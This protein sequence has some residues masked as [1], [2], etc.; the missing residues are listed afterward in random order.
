MA[1]VK[2]K[3]VLLTGA[4]G[5]MGGEAFKELLQRRDKCDIVLILRPSKPNREAFGKYDGQPGVTIVWGDLCNPND[6][7]K[8]VTGV[9]HVLHPAALIA[10]EAD[11][12]PRQCRQVNF[13]GTQNIIA[14]IKKQPNN[15]DGIR[16][17]YIGSVA[18]YGDRLP[19]IHWIRVGDPLKPSVGDY[20]A[21]TKIAAE[22]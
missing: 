6:V 10:P 2:K 15:G 5:S 3:R 18:E 11:S 21:T 8:A 13:G 19:P 14:A 22:K 12:K 7:L 4:S 9:D 17:V 20:Y 1:D 16:F